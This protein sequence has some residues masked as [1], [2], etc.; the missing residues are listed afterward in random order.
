MISTAPRM[1]S[2]ALS[3]LKEIGTP[4]LKITCL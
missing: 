2:G 1:S 3:V 4:L